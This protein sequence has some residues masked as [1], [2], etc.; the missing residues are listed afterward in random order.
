MRKTYL[1]FNASTHIAPEV[2]RAMRPYLAELNCPD[3]YG[4]AY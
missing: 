4:A 1:D 3:W 2:V